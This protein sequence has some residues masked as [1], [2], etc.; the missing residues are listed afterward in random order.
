MQLLVSGHRRELFS[1]ILGD[2]GARGGEMRD[3]GGESGGA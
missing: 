3:L 1:S 2:C